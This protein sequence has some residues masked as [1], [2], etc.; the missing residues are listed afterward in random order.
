MAKNY[1]ETLGVA[2][3]ASADEIKKAY[4]KLAHK[5]HPDKGQ[6][7]DAQFKEVNEA[8]QVLSDSAKR[9]Q[10]DQYGETFEQARANGNPNAGQ[11][12]GQGSPFGDF[13]F[14][15]GGVD[16]DFGEIFSDIFGGQQARTQRRTRG[17]DLEMPITLTFEEAA[18]GVEKSITLEKKD[19]CPTCKGTGAEPGTKV[20]TCPVCH[21]QGQIRTT[22]RTIFGNMQSATTCERCDGEGKIPEKPCHTCDGKGVLRQQKTL[23]VKIPAGIDN[24]QRIRIS[25]EG[26]VG[27][28]A[29]DPGDL[30]LSIKVKPSKDF[31]RQ[32]PNLLK[33]LPISF[34]QAALG[35]KV[36]VPTLDGDIEVKI[37]AGTQSGHIL[38]AASKGIT[39]VN[40]GKKGDLLLTVRVVTPHKLTKKETELLKELAKMQGESVEVNEGFWDSIK[41]SF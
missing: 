5:Y 7:N 41:N 8:Y 19:K 37:P 30:Y 14:G 22:R 11:S 15:Q 28:R 29:S 36:K 24:G 38:R 3:S 2:K 21:G 10:Y 31:T 20:I 4:R 13:G 1:Y 33:D 39:I 12:Y 34:A 32:G 27:Y 23:Q 17:V 35:A 18:H 40:S 16:F 26:E 6:G 9:S 25:G